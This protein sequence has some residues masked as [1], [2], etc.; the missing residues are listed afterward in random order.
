M[1]MEGQTQFSHIPIYLET[2]TIVSTQ[3]SIEILALSLET[4]TIK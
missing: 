2:S 3:G 1:L 4:S